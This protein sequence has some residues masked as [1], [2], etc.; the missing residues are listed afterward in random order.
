MPRE[1]LLRRLLTIGNKYSRTDCPSRVL[2]TDDGNRETPSDEK[3][4]EA[5]KK[6]LESYY[7]PGCLIPVAG[8]GKK[9]GQELDIPK[10]KLTWKFYQLVDF[11]IC[12]LADSYDFYDDNPARTPKHRIYAWKDE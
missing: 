4:Q 6:V 5:T 9:V 8:I 10:K 12:A 7:K 2:D 11:F 3:I 1:W